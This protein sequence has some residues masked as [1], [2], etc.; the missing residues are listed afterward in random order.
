MSHKLAKQRR[1]EGRDRKTLTHQRQLRELV[2]PKSSFAVVPAHRVVQYLA[3]REQLDDYLL[4]DDG[5]LKILPAAAYERFDPDF[6]ALWCKEMGYHLLPTVEL[7]DWLR[8]EIGDASAIEICA[9]AGVLGQALGVPSIDWD[10]CGRFP[11]AK[12]CYLGLANP[13]AAEA[14]P[15]IGPRCERIE[16]MEAIAKYR[17]QV[18]FGGYVTQRLYPGE[19]D[20]MAGSAFGVEECTL[21]KCVRK[22]IV[23]STRTTQQDKRIFRQRTRELSPPW[24]VT[25]HPDPAAALISVWGKPRA[26]DRRGSAA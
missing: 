8:S 22:Y 16:A 23:L 2:V 17:P 24:L 19:P 26:N 9:G 11:A 3:V 7:V 15:I 6:R 4:G 12:A 21:I 1:A 14:I 18:V 20:W 5:L 25:R 10:V 13:G